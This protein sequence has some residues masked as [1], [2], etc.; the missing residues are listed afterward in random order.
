[1]FLSLKT[2]LSLEKGLWVSNKNFSSGKNTFNVWRVHKDQN[3]NGLKSILT[4][5]SYNR[6]QYNLNNKQALELHLLLD[7]DNSAMYDYWGIYICAETFRMIFYRQIQPFGLVNFPSDPNIVLDVARVHHRKWLKISIHLKLKKYFS[8]TFLF[9][10]GVCLIYSSYLIFFHRWAL[11]IEYRMVVS[12]PKIA[13]V[14]SV[15]FWIL[16]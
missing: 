13:E 10:Y 15:N 16:L 3:L 4:F 12:S 14:H 8:D 11:Y 1:M 7:L 9:S 2:I 5:P 6:L